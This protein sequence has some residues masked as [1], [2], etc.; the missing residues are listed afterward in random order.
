MAEQVG[1]LYYDLTIKDDKFNKSL[2]TATNNTQNLD[3]KITK[4]GKSLK[5]FS[6]LAKVGAVVAIGSFALAMRKA[7]KDA[8]DLEETTNKFNVVFSDVQDSANEMAKV[9]VDSYGASK[10]GALDALSATG[11]LLTGMGLQQEKA[12]ELSF[13]TAKLAEDLASFT[14]IEGGAERVTRALTSAYTGEREALKSVGIVI[15]EKAVKDK[16]LLNGQENLTGSAL[17]QAKAEATLA[18]AIEQSGNAIGDKERSFD[19]FANVQKRIANRMTD[20]SAELGKEL[21]PEL[22]KLGVLFLEVSGDG[23]V[24][25]SA[26]KGMLKIII[27]VA[28][29]I[30]KIIGAVDLWNKNR[31]L[32]KI[33]EKLEIYR[34][35]QIALLVGMKQFEQAGFFS[36]TVKKKGEKFILFLERVIKNTKKHS[37]EQRKALYFYDRLVAIGKAI[38][39]LSGAQNESV[40]EMLGSAQSLS[41]LDHIQTKE[42]KKQLALRLKAAKQRDRNLNTSKKQVKSEKDRNEEI[43]KRAALEKEAS[44]FALGFADPIAQI[45]AQEKAKLD[46]LDE[47][48][49]KN[50]DAVKNAQ[51]IEE[52]IK[53]E[54]ARKQIELRAQQA[55]TTL[56]TVASQ[57]GQL[58]ELYAMSA[59]NDT[60]RIDNATQVKMTALT[61]EYDAEV[62]AINN[63]V[64]SQEDKD[65]KLTALDEKRA[66]DEKAIEDKA[67][68]DKR[69]IAYDLAVAQ[70]KLR[71]AETLLMIPQASM[72]AWT[73]AMTLPYPYNL[74]AGGS[75]V[76]AT[77]ALGAAKVAMISQQPLPQLA[78]GGFIGATAGGTDVTVG[79]GRFD[80]AVIPLSDVFYNRLASGITNALSGVSTETGGTIEPVTSNNQAINLNLTID[81]GSETFYTKI[82]NAIAN[83]EIVIELDNLAVQ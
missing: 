44:A 80:E 21:L 67:S 79:E 22:S 37:N 51:G 66:R 73:S 58:S 13:A 36:S 20:I 53:A 17:L 70:K 62:E 59:Q 52:K 23:S 8:S 74:I 33:T 57:L 63:S 4:T 12:L 30:A 11:D 34:K 76:A 65:K 55:F 83:R 82:E 10:E 39:R 48:R 16:L 69:K 18:L 49:K 78:N 41:K 64:L 45:E 3:K 7:V 50:L 42:Q 43:K 24:F 54:S 27:N 40:Q 35:Q 38:N 31:N 56:S 81:T 9:L 46:K 77:V 61:S 2:K 60:M 29:G 71:I 15:S 32:D 1:E 19:S 75:S 25:M 68:K 6:T 72:A 28:K 47:Y 14:N 5:K 26:L